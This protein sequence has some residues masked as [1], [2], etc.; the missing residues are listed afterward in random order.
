MPKAPKSLGQ[1]RVHSLYGEIIEDK[2]KCV[3]SQGRPIRSAKK[4]KKQS[5]F[6][7]QCSDNSV[8][9]AKETARLMK[10]ARAQ[11]EE[12]N[13]GKFE[14][15]NGGHTSPIEDFSDVSDGSD[16]FE[17]TDFNLR[18]DNEQDYNEQDYKEQDFDWEDTIEI[19]PEDERLFE[20]ECRSDTFGGKSRN[21]ADIIMA[22]I[23]EK[24]SREDKSRERSD[25]PPKVV[26][27]YSK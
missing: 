20:N 12:L 14:N 23:K 22:K 16:Q 27:V 21:L 3:R 26:L 17:D 15:L 10:L 1:S 19:D 7:D 25:F 13:E 2:G 24:E 5:Q 11:R 18:D 9:N 6:N 4:A 8:L